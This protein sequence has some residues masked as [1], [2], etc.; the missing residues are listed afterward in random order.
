MKSKSGINLQ[1]YLGGY[2]GLNP[3]GDDKKSEIEE[4]NNYPS[5]KRKSTML[6]RILKHLSEQEQREE[7]AIR[8]TLYLNHRLM[9]M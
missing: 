1:Q 7:K 8:I 2:D 3:V 5:K 9:T 6:E 4:K